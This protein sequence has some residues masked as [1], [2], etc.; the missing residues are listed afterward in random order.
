M[1]TR[2]RTKAAPEAT[3][4]LLQAAKKGDESIVP[5]WI[6][7]NANVEVVDGDNNRGM[8]PIHYA[9][10]AGHWRVVEH[11]IGARADINAVNADG[12]TPILLAIRHHHY[13]VV[14][15][16]VTAGCDVNVRNKKGET[17]L[18]AACVYHCEHV[19]DVLV[20]GGR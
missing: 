6:A 20:H 11:L 19:I 15:P 18:L 2:T 1:A 10:E 5:F 9:A 12:D 4:E 17:A 13:S 8:R 14:K 16:L 3:A 7:S